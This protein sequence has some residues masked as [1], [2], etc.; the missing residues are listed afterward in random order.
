SNIQQMD[1]VCDQPEKQIASINNKLP[2]DPTY[3]SDQAA[4][5]DGAI[6]KKT[7]T[8]ITKTKTTTKEKEAKGVKGENVD[9]QQPENLA[10]VAAN[11]ALTLSS[12]FNK[13]SLEELEKL[14]EVFPHVIASF[15]QDRDA[16]QDRA[17]SNESAPPA[18]EEHGPS[19]ST[20]SL[21]SA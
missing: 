15:S 19:S 10:H 6:P 16:K 1:T 5:N 7:T 20:H 12:F 21:S 4:T 11:A 14:V 3:M 8:K 2:L 17:E 9:E 13:F 18:F